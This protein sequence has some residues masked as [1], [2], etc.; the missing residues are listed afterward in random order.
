MWGEFSLYHEIWINVL[1]L[2]CFFPQIFNFLAVWGHCKKRKQQ[3]PVYPSTRPSIHNLGFG[4][5]HQKK[6]LSLLSSILPECTVGS[7]LVLPFTGWQYISEYLM[8]LLRAKQFIRA[9]SSMTI[10]ERPMSMYSMC[11]CVCVEWYRHGGIN[12]AWIYLQPCWLTWS[13]FY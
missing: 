10:G 8:G 2:F 1:Q 6:A 3:T 9:Q 11:M 12:Y 5:W 13:S 4:M 7:G